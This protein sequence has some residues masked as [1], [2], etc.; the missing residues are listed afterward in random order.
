MGIY[1]DIKINKIKET[2]KEKSENRDYYKG[3]NRGILIS[4]ANKNIDL[5]KSTKS[6]SNIRRPDVV[7]PYLV[8][9]ANK[10]IDLSKSTK[11]SYRSK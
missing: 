7:V 8:K 10:N 5:S 3:K 2:I 1:N 6:H 4:N 11:S 9:N